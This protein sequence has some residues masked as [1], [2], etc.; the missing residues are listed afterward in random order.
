MDGPRTHETLEF[1][2]FLL[3][4]EQRVLRARATRELIHLTPKAFDTLLVLVRHQG[5]LIDK[6]TLMSTVWPNVIVEENNLNQVISAIRKALGDSATEHRYIV[7]SPGR[8][9]RFVA[10]VKM[11]PLSDATA[12]DT[13]PLPAETVQ[14]A[15]PATS[16]QPVARFTVSRVVI[17]SIV[18]LALASGLWFLSRIEREEPIE[19]LRS[20][21]T[22]TG[23]DLAEAQAPLPAAGRLR[24]AILPFENLSDNPGVA[25]FAEGLHEEI[26]STIARHAPDV[27]V[28]S[29]IT[30]MAYRS[31]PVPVQKVARDLNATHL[32]SGSVRRERDTV[33]V[34]L[35]LVDAR[36]DRLLWSQNYDRT[37]SNVLTLQSE[38]AAEVASQLSVRLAAGSESAAAPTKSPEAYDL[39]LKALV[40][41]QHLSPFAPIE[42]YR[43]VDDLLT[44]AIALDPAFVSA[45]AQRATFRIV[46]FAFNYDVSEEHLRRTRDDVNAALR[47]AP[48][49]PLALAAQA[50]YLSWVERDLPRAMTAYEAAEAAHLADSMFLLGKSGVLIRM[51]R[52]AEANRLNERVMAIDPATP[53]IIAGTAQGLTYQ[54]KPQEGL[55]ILK[56][57]LELFPDDPWL[58]LLQAQILF[59]FTG[60]LDEWRAALNRADL[61]ATRQLLLDQHFKLLRLEGRYAEL[62]NLLDGISVPT[63]R[64]TSGGAA[65]SYYGAGEQPMAEYGGWAALLL[66]DGRTA[67]RQGRGV[68]DFLGNANETS[69]NAWFRRLLLAEAHAF[70]GENARAISHAREAVEL[71]PASR[72]VL[73]AL[74]VASRAAAVYAWSGAQDEA[75]SLLEELAAGVPGVAPAFVARD[76]IFATP[77]AHN[78]RYRALAARL[79]EEMRTSGL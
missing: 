19:P 52:V 24:L 46:I 75:V 59:G 27:D 62:Q 14:T 44:Q 57:G 55:R 6:S 64:I 43:E 56:R 69:R 51:G 25:F 68:L 63:I 47:L 36:S 13:R 54:R 23:P 78:S 4:V 5:E 3:D 58:A 71:M 40:A 73:T 49:D 20:A 45:Y 66:G 53:F 79:E 21:V 65:S 42:R 60:R 39:Y 30:M 12:S 2:E 35:Q 8:G 77:L 9:Y 48:T 74:E 38:V 28:I 70:L 17:T 32:I 50:S 72:D 26:L 33:R 34:T 76:P 37:L 18:V 29:R 22:Q 31:A 7:T 10:P 15:P 1:G 61:Q 41:R 67:A 11:V 16:I